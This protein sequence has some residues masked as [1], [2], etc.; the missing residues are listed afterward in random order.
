MVKAAR[1][2]SAGIDGKCLRKRS[3]TGSREGEEYTRS[4]KSRDSGCVSGKS[5]GKGCS[6]YKLRIDRWHK[7]IFPS[8][9]F[10]S[11]T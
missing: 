7:T 9:H 4:S 10:S 11:T 3:C 1:R 8:E 6:K 5:V 2:A